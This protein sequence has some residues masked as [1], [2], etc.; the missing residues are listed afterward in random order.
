MEKDL[1]DKKE[2]GIGYASQ[3]EERGG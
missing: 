1:G 2:G 3:I